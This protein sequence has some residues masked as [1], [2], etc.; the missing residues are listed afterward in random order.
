M[1]YYAPSTPSPGSDSTQIGYSYTTTLT[2]AT[3]PNNNTP[4]N[5]ITRISNIPI[6]VWLVST[7][8]IF[9][10]GQ[11]SSGT[12]SSVIISS[13]VTVELNM[14]TFIANSSLSGT[15]SPYSGMSHT[16]CSTFYSNGSAYLDV[17][18]YIQV[19]NDTGNISGSITLTK[20]A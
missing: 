6:G 16:L 4:G 14:T 20:I 17:G 11:K 13:Y 1:A 19:N 3:A 7:T 5:K 9:A 10:E 18:L 2:T 8:D 15:G 12:P